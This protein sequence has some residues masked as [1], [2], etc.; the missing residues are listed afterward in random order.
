ML[1]VGLYIHGL[2]EVLGFYVSTGSNLKSSENIWKYIRT[3]VETHKIHRKDVSLSIDKMPSNNSL[4]HELNLLYLTDVSHYH[5]STF[6][7][8]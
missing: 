2:N 3:A 7:I 4:N 6:S 8:V 1:L 5:E